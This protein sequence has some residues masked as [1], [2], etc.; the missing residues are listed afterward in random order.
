MS[1]RYVFTAIVFILWILGFYLATGFSGKDLANVVSEVNPI[2]LAAGVLFYIIAVFSGILVLYI[3]LRSVGLTPPLKGVSKAWIFG[4]FV[5]NVAPTVTPV[6]EAS[7]AYF[8]ERF[9]RVSY[10]KSLAAIGMYVSSWGLSVSVF[11][12]LSVLIAQYFVGIPPGFLPVVTV[13]IIIFSA[14]TLGWLLLLTRKKVVKSLVCRF[15]SIFNKIHNI[16]KRKNITYD[17]CVF[18]IEFERSYKSLE[19]LMKNKKHLAGSVFLFLVPQL[20][21][22]LCLYSILL[23]LGAQ[24]SFFEVLTI[25]IVAMVAGLISLIPSGLGVY[26]GASVGAFALTLGVPEATALGAVFLYRLI[27]VWMTNFIGGAIGIIQG[28]ED[29]KISKV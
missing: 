21:H 7:M 3:S 12:I 6:G 25:Q 14:I 23:G 8:L 17:P 1:K 9:Y 20:A 2:N 10:T 27:F 16:I 22:V 18:M 5:D 26:E 29:A 24:V 15:V 13:V 11:A 19:S 28:V 4:S